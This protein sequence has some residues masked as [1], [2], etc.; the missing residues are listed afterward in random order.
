MSKNE[1]KEIIPKNIKSL[2]QKCNDELIEIYDLYD[3]EKF[4]DYISKS[5]LREQPLF[6]M[7]RMIGLSFE[8]FEDNEKALYDVFSKPFSFPMSVG[9]VLPA[10]YPNPVVP[11][12]GK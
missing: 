7:S 5:H 1:V 4:D 11:V 3:D 10:T 8:I 12:N 9:V 6:L 2:I